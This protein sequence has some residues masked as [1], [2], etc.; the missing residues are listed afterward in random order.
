MV[1]ALKNTEY[2]WNSLIRDVAVAISKETGNIMGEK[3]FPMIESRMKRRC[4][5]L[6]ITSPSDYKRYWSQHQTEE[7]KHLIGLLTTHFT[8]FFREFSHFEWI[9]K[10]LPT[11]VAH[12]KKE[13]RSTIKIWSA[14][15]SKGQEVWSL[16]MWLQFHLPKIDPTMNWQV[17]GSDIDPVSVKEG[18]NAVYHRRELETAPRHLWE[19]YWVKGKGEISDW[20]KIKSELKTRARFQTMNLLNVQINEKFDIILCRNV[21]IYFDRENQENIARSLLKQLTPEGTL[22]T[23]MSESLSGFGLPIRGVSPSVYKPQSA[24]VIPLP[25]KATTTSTLE[26]P[27]PL[28]VFCIDDSPTVLTILKKILKAPDFEVIGF[29]SNGQEAI[30]KLHTLKPDV[31]TLDLHMPVMDGPTFLKQSEIAKRIPVIVVSSVGREH[32]PVMNQLSGSGVSDFVEKPTL[33]NINE[34]GDELVQKLRMG[35]LTK[36]NNVKAGQLSIA[37]AKKRPNGT[38][39]FNFG[40]KD[41]KNLLHVLNE[42]KWEND[43]IVFCFNG[44][45][46]QFE[47][48]KHKLKSSVFRAKNVS[49]VTRTEI[50]Q[51]SSLPSIWL[52]FKD[53][54]FDYL[55]AY[56]KATDYTVAEET[57]VKSSEH[58]DDE[59]PVTSF[60]YLVDKL[61]GGE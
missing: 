23:G 59:S 61:L 8:S 19:G 24:T 4:S 5:E 13:G 47:E 7:N 52:H 33:A 49:Y 34:I 40:L 51:R 2:N 43:E 57:T 39:L 48:I 35:W 10:E 6:K 22:I 36:K 26:I 53:G 12:A 3:Q 45:L 17:V 27:K 32:A 29:A 55:K 11:I 50:A 28:K 18:E 42:Q 15:S 14:A 20:Y 31:I 9:A 37:A 58:V 60:S 38:I 21:L 56:K 46:P 54:S 44:S 30:E 41:E 25:V 1:A 16:C